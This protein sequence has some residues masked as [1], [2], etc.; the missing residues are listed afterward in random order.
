[1][2]IEIKNKNLLIIVLVLLLLSLHTLV[3]SAT[4]TCGT[5]GVDN[6][7][8]PS[9]L[10]N[11]IDAASDGDKINIASGNHSWASAGSAGILVDKRITISGGGSC[12]NCGDKAIPSGNWPATIDIGNSQNQVFRIRCPKNG[13]PNI[14]RIS[15][16]KLYG[17][18]RFAY[19]WWSDNPGG[20]IVVS[21]KNYAKYRIDNNYFR[22]T[23]TGA[24]YDACQIIS[25][26]DHTYGLIDNNFMYNE[27]ADGGMIQCYKSGA[28]TDGFEAYA[29]NPNWGTDN[30]L[31]VEDNTFYYACEVGY[32]SWDPGLLMP[33]QA[34]GM[35]SD[36]ILSETA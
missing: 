18:T 34:A 6:S 33:L 17:Q 5:N 35:Y 22:N 19:D 13:N 26:N 2:T 1:M 30:F 24:S 28:S 31:F 14:V 20:F 16:L 4:Y 23:A 21:T 15:G 7:C 29:E 12:K 27:G 9:K 36:I 11:L 3:L 10:D 25:N 32:T 8:T